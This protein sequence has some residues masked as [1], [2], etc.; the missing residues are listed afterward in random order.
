MTDKEAMAMALVALDIVKIH[1]TQ[2]RH[3]DEG[4][5]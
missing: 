2:N 1:Y 4:R 3:I 5:L